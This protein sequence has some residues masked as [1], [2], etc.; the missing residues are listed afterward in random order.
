M[1]KTYKSIID[2]FLKLIEMQVNKEEE[3][4][5]TFSA[6]KLIGIVDSY[7]KFVNT[8]PHKMLSKIIGTVEDDK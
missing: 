7:E 1:E 2:K 8:I 5:N 3:S 6:T 4:L